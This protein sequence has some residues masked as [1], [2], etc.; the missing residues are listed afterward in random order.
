MLAISDTGVGMDA[1]TRSRIFEPFF[2]TKGSGRGTGLG[3]AML[4]ELREAE[5]RLRQ[6]LQRAGP[7]HHLQDLPAD[8]GAAGAPRPLAATGQ[9]PSGSETILVVEDDYAVR[10]FTEAVL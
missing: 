10:Q 7:G 1:V 3:L 6:G 9:A 4:H 2:T 8:G 5:R